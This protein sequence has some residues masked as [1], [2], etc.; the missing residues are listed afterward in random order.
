M[1]E[2]ILDIADKLR[3]GEITVD[4][5]KELLLFLFGTKK[6]YMVTFQYMNST[7]ASFHKQEVLAYSSDEALE[8]LYETNSKQINTFTVSVKK[9]T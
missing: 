2:H 8:I 6:R 3:N 9:I 7:D 4:Q 5:A 1:K